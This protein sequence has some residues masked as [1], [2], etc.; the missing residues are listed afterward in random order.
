MWWATGCEGYGSGVRGFV[1]VGTLF[2]QFIRHGVF[3]VA[4]H[5]VVVE[6]TGGGVNLV[7][8]LLALSIFQ[9][10]IEAHDI[11]HPGKRAFANLGFDLGCA[12][13]EHFASDRELALFG[14]AVTAA[15]RWPAYL[16]KDFEQL[17]LSDTGKVIG[18]RWPPPARGINLKHSAD[19]VVEPTVMRCADYAG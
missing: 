13:T 8:I 19:V 16:F 5:C 9:R 18:S 11:W 10:A 6:V 15:K 2:C 7:A 17:L 12:S 4:R 1:G 14:G 3:P